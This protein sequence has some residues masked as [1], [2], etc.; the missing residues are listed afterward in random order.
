MNGHILMFDGP[1][2]GLTPESTFSEVHSALRKEGLGYH[3]FMHSSEIT[4]V[5]DNKNYYF[6]DRITGRCDFKAG[7]MPKNEPRGC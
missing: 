7:P 6:K 4:V 1:R 3:F 2:L 5:F